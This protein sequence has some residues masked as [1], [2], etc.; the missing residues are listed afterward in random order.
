MY[1]AGLCRGKEE[2]SNFGNAV[3]LYL[4]IRESLEIQGLE[5]FLY[6]ISKGGDIEE[7]G[8]DFIM[9]TATDFSATTS[10]LE[11]QFAL[12]R[13]AVQDLEDECAIISQ[14]VKEVRV[15]AEIYRRSLA[16]VTLQEVKDEQSRQ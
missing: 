6:G 10:V 5:L 15:L 8:E 3:I 2:S 11:Q 12:V 14:H 7:S 1:P 4:E 16:R 9:D 13:K